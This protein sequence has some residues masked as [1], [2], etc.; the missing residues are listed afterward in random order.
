MKN[1]FLLSLVFTAQIA[2]SQEKTYSVGEFDIINDGV[3]NT[4]FNS[5]GVSQMHMGFD[6]TTGY[7]KFGA[8][9]GNGFRNDI[10]YMRGSDGNVGIGTADPISKLT[11][12]GSF[13]INGGLSNISSRPPIS[14]GTLTNGEIRAYSNAWNAADDG[15]LRLSAG[16]GTNPIKTFIDLSGYSTIPDM[17]GNIVFGTYGYERMRLNL[18]GN[19]GIGT[20]NP[21]QKLVVSNNNAEGFEVYLDPAVSVVGLQ[22]YNRTL[23]AYSKMQL[24][25]SQFAFMYGKVGIGKLNPSNDLDVNGTIHSKEVKIDLNFPAPDYVFKDDYNLRPLQEVENYIK[26]NSHLPEIPSAKEFEENG[27]NVSEMNMALLKKI[28][29]LTLYMIEMKKE[30]EKQNREIND[31]KT[32]IRLQNK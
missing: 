13:T 17:A 7:V 23:S 19:L 32:V 18:T 30:N 12:N 16:G 15:F 28:E 22:S 24:D 6:G 10:L 29:E 5:N 27:I 25:A 3:H 21:Q 11:A 14:A 20:N 9:T 26:E 31:L 1:I 8:H 2:I 4:T